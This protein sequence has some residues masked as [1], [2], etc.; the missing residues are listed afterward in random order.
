M[1][2]GGQIGGAVVGILTPILAAQLGWS[3]SFLFT[4]GVCILGAVAWFFIDPYATLP[5]NQAADAAQPA[6]PHA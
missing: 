1:N 6:S 4:A 2:M 5:A 3:G